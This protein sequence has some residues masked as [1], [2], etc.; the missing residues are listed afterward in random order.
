MRNCT[1]Q[2]RNLYEILLSGLCTLR[3]CCC[4]LTGLAQAPSDYAITV[5]YN[6]NSSEC[7]GATTFGNLGY[8]VDSNQTVFQFNVTIYFYFIHCHIV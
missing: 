8:T 4:N 6:D 5:T 7:K 3:D 2:Y 1:F